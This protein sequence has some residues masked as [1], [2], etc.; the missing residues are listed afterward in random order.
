MH[1]LVS[2]AATAWMQSSVDVM[3]QYAALVEDSEARDAVLALV[4]AEHERTRVALEAIYTGPLAAVRNT[5]HEALQRRHAALRPL[6]ERQIGLLRAWRIAPDDAALPE[7]LLTVNAI[8][9][10]LGATG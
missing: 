1:Y 5:I 7:L 2:N 3:Q 4:M 6:H 10:G 8:A 9:S